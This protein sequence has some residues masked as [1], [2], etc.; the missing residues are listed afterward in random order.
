[1]SY[2]IP[3]ISKLLK[4]IKSQRVITPFDFKE[5]SN[6]ICTDGYYIV[7]YLTK[8]DVSAHL[9]VYQLDLKN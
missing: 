1:M 3:L 6:V 8:K 9:I 4:F 5:I 7:N 2:P